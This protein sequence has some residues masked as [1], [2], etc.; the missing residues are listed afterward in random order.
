VPAT[1]VAT[2]GL[3]LL[4]VPPDVPFDMYVVVD[5]IQSGSKPLTEPAVTFG[6]TV[7]VLNADT[8]LPQPLL[9]VYVILVVPALTAV[10]TPVPAT[11]VATDGL[12]LLQLPPVVPSDV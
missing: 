4:H 5:P 3:V 6:L 1:T 9:I 12:L 7:N 2:A 10:T 11:T 8:G